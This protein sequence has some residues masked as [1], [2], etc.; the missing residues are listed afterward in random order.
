MAGSVVGISRTEITIILVIIAG[1][2][3]GVAILYFL[4]R[5]VLS[6]RVLATGPQKACA[7]CGKMADQKC[8]GCLVA[9]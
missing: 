8:R 6:P 5:F 1:C 9:L 3:L 4:N 7:R 2:V